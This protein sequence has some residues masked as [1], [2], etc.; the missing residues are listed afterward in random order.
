MERVN[1]ILQ[2]DLY[3]EYLEKNNQAEK[4]RKF[5]RH[6]M[7]HFLDVARIAVI[8][9]QKEHYGID[10]EMIYAAAL[11]HDIGRWKQYEDGTPHER[12]SAALAPAILLKSGFDKKET[13]AIVLAISN[14]RNKEIME[15]KDLNGLLYR[16]DK[17][18]RPCFAC[19]MEKECNW[20]NER[21]NL[22]LKV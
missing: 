6:D 21:K 2:Q 20:K 7:A 8:L 19:D 13:D 4:E 5:C 10:D 9:N 15:Q 11:L 14:H 18:S 3:R 16:S 1:L 12:A 17:Q 22:L